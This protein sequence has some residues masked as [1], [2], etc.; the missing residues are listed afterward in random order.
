MLI[1]LAIRFLGI[2]NKTTKRIMIDAEN[3]VS[4]LQEKIRVAFGIPINEQILRF[5]I[6]NFEIRI[7]AGFTFEF[8]EIGNNSVLVLWLIIVAAT[9]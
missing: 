2:K 4:E 7:V 8:Y 3:D 1:Q 5:K 6:Q 9:K